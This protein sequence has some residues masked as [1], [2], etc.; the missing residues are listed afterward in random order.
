MSEPLSQTDEVPEIT[1]A[2]SDA[3][4]NAFLISLSNCN[5][6]DG[7]MVDQIFR[8]MYRV[9]LKERHAKAEELRHKFADPPI[10]VFEKRGNRSWHVVEYTH[11]TP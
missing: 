9:M 7:E 10:S 2:M 1:P 6:G 3:G 8:A 11:E 5:Q 4:Y